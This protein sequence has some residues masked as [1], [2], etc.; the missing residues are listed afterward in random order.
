EEH[1]VVGGEVDQERR[2][3]RREMADDR[4]PERVHYARE[5]LKKSSPTE[6]LGDDVSPR[7]RGPNFGKL[8]HLRRMSFHS[9]FISSIPLS[10]ASQLGPRLRGDD[11]PAPFSGFS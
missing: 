11:Y 2:R 7:R 1:P 5:G 6:T 10:I 4:L 3:D 8:E 9:E